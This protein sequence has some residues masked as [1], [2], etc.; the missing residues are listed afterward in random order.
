M[1]TTGYPSPVL[2]S[3]D[4]IPRFLK[5]LPH[6]CRWRRGVAPNGRPT[7]APERGHSTA[8][9]DHC[10]P[11]SAVCDEPR[12]AHGGIGF[13]MTWTRFTLDPGRLEWRTLAF[14]LDACRQPATGV[15][16][17]WALAIVRHFASY[18]EV[19]PS[20]T[21]LRVWVHVRQDRM[22]DD[23]ASAKVRV[24]YAAP[25]GVDKT[26]EI[27][28]FGLG[29]AQYVT[30]TGWRL[31]EFPGEIAY[32]EG[33]GLEWLLSNFGFRRGAEARDL[34]LPTGLGDPP[35]LETIEQRIREAR[36]G[37]ALADGR[38]QEVFPKKSA[39]EA[40]HALVAIVVRAAEGHGALAAEWLLRSPWGR[41]L[42]HESR[43]PRKYTRADWV[44]R[45]V[46]RAAAKMPSRVD[47]AGAFDVLE[48]PAPAS[49]RVET[50]AGAPATA[51]GAAPPDRLMDSVEFAASTEGMNW[52]VKGLLPRVGLAQ[53]Y[54]DPGC[55]KTPVALG[56]A[57]R[58]ATV[59]ADEFFGHDVRHHGVVVYMV[60][61]GRAG[62]ARRLRAECRAQGLDLES[63][64][65]TLL[66]TRSP[67]QLTSP[68]DAARW[69]A[70]ILRRAPKG[71]ALLVIDTQARNFGLGNENATEDMNAFVINLAALSEGLH[72]L[73]LLVHHTG[74]MNK[75]RGRGS[76]ALFGALDACFEVT[77]DG[78][79]VTVSSTKE[80]DWETPEPLRGTLLPVT[81]GHD[82]DG[83]EI[84][85][86]T[87]DD[88]PPSD[89][90]V[91]ENLRSELADDGNLARVWLAVSAL[92][93]RP[94]S[95]RKL[96]EACG[97]SK[98]EVARK[99]KVLTAKRV[100]T[101]GRKGAE[102]TYP[103]TE[104]G[105][106]CRLSQ[107]TLGQLG[108]SGDSAFS[109]LSQ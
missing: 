13:V 1:E 63:L 83:D 52:L 40:Y 90:E 28:I 100:I 45:D 11:W 7:K 94:V 101:P 17:P 47:P 91:F 36:H 20:G 31:E 105:L 27:Q 35:S 33:P 8:N 99:L 29:V 78:R 82:E 60:G 38:W 4:H 69:H 96:A 42:I 12:N 108:D 39:S 59:S 70:E 86:I 46:M 87:L 106:N 74:H 81:L 50:P 15:I 71:L 67:G 62:L 5:D 54:G 23:L 95:T 21:G 22:P 92:D 55:G 32:H 56:L 104:K 25:E 37:A 93:G 18:S 24:P 80:K 64:R 30:V 107:E 79:E 73:V 49:V 51:G 16:E 41:G 75:E 14:D 57:I 102:R 65:E 103:L 109:E 89:A 98:T 77:R 34:E 76:S 2:F 3:G 58:V 85:A 72:C 88:R 43:D 61:E 68:E 10:L 9:F 26:P 53:V 44:A 19:T 84:T 48:A 6:W 66:W 97:I